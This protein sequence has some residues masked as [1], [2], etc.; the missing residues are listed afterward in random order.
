MTHDETCLRFLLNF[1]ELLLCPSHSKSL[2]SYLT[3]LSLLIEFRLKVG[4][5]MRENGMK[6]T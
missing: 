5:E 2:T 4:K 6:V 1:Y 3:G